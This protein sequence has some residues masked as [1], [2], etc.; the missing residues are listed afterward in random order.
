M[1]TFHKLTIE[2]ISKE[3]ADAVS[4]L[5][6]IPAELKEAY[7]FVAGQYITVKTKIRKKRRC[8]MGASKFG[9]R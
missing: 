5:F 8:F 1:S 4:I 2:K 6:T 9:N 3:T 7:S